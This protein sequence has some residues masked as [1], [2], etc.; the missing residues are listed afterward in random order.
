MPRFTA[1]GQTA[2]RAAGN[3]AL[4]LES[5]FPNYFATLQIGIVRGRAFDDGDREGTS[6]WRSSATTWPSGRGRA[7]NAIGKRLKMGGPDSA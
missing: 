1:E 6:W 4:N 5:I 3:P 7:R 2:E